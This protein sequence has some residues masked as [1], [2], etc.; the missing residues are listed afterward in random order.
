LDEEGEK[1]LMACLAQLKQR[2]TTTLVISHRQSV[3]QM[4]THMV[5]VRDGVMQAFGERDQVI[6]A[7]QKA[8]AQQQAGKA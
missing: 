5:V 3:L 6:A 7:L 4:A 2:Q 8:Y 1:A